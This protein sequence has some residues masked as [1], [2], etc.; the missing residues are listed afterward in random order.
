MLERRRGTKLTG[1]RAQSKQYGIFYPVPRRGVRLYGRMDIDSYHS[2]QNGRS[3][4][5]FGKNGAQGRVHGTRAGR[6]N[7][8]GS[9]GVLRGLQEEQ[10]H[11][12]AVLLEAPRIHGPVQ[13]HR[14]ES[15]GGRTA[16]LRRQHADGIVGKRRGAGHPG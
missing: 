3:F 2:M 1:N 16:N 7:C 6:L 9:R 11:G 12:R 15:L 4:E 14:G 5:T 13:R 10:L 8:V